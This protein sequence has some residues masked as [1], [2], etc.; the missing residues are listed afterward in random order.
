MSYTTS[1]DTILQAQLASQYPAFHEVLAKGVEAMRQASDLQGL[2]ALRQQ[3]VQPLEASTVTR[4]A[5]E[6]GV[7][8]PGPVVL[9][10]SV[11]LDTEQVP[12]EH[13][14]VEPLAAQSLTGE[15]RLQGFHAQLESHLYEPYRQ[16]LE[17][18]MADKR[19]VFPYTRKVESI[20]GAITHG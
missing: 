4:I 15:T 12:G 5:L 6:V 11:V 14:L 19:Q 1:W 3:V 16:K 9:F 2:D 20:Q 8:Q 10:N 18:L 17:C 13:W 7:V